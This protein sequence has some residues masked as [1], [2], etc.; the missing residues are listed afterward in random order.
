METATEALQTESSV[1]SSQEFN[2]KK[3]VNE[4]VENAVSLNETAQRYEFV[5]NVIIH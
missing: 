5:I 1:Q 4:I 2:V 3:T